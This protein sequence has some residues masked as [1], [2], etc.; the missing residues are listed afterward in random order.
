MQGTSRGQ[1]LRRMLA[2][3]AVVA[4]AGV[5]TA[6][7]YG[8]LA[9]PD[10]AASGNATLAEVA[11]LS[12]GSG[13][14]RAVQ[15]AAVLVCQATGDGSYVTIRVLPERLDEYR[16]NPNNIVPAPAGGCPARVGGGSSTTQTTPS[17]TQTTPPRTT[18]TTSTPTPTRTQ[19]TPTRTQTTPRPT[20]T[21]TQTTTR[22]QATTPT[23]TRT[24]TTPTRTS[25]TPRPTTST[26]ADTTPA[27][28]STTST[29]T[30]PSSGTAGASTSG[31]G[32]SSTKRASQRRFTGK[33]SGDL[34]RLPNTGNDETALL[35]LGGLALFM[36]GT[37]L[38][39][40]HRPLRF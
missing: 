31:G 15:Q 21:R 34:S 5:G 37:G 28:V 16:Q 40:R 8:A 3:G 4:A 25:T 17:T 12:G 20:P 32:S 24:Q 27:P 35:L 9:E 6:F 13:G 1:R 22:P 36:A 18:T 38:H 7:A 10:G 33:M 2:S 30:T 14:L 39:L 26:Q 23:P 11:A 29:T 19:T